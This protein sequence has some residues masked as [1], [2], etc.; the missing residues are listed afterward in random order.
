MRNNFVLLACVLLGFS[1]AFGKSEAQQV[2]SQVPQPAR[3]I[4]LDLPGDPRRPVKLRVP[5]VF[6]PGTGPFPLA[7]WNHGS[8]GEGLIVDEKNVGQNMGVYYLLSRGYAVA[9]PLMRGF[10]QSGG[11][12]SATG[13]QLDDLAHDTAADL[14]AVIDHLAKRSEFAADRILVAGSSFGGWNSLALGALQG[15]RV[16]AI[17]NFYGGLHSS[18]CRN[19]SGALIESS[20]RIGARNPVPS[21]WI[22]GSNDRLFPKPLWQAMHHAYVTRGGQA[23]LVDFGLYKSNSHKLLS[24]PYSIVLF[25][26]KVDRF[27]ASVGLPSKNV[28]P[29]YVPIEPPQPSGYASI[30]DIDAVPF[31]NEQGQALY[32]KF[33]TAVPPRVF[34]I[35]PNA[36]VISETG[37]FDPLARAMTT[38]KQRKVTCWPYAFNDAVVWAYPTP[39]PPPS[40]FAKLE[41][42]DALPYVDVAGKTAYRQFLTAKRPR[43]FVIAPSGAWSMAVGDVDP[44]AAALAKCSGEDHATCRPY[45]VDRMVVWPQTATV[46]H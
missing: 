40:R 44:V 32:K 31:L 8:N 41:D 33:L 20:S 18:T 1:S 43:A 36:V 6:P 3:R 27:L 35:A 23:E 19:D 39:S 7:L 2:G 10:G 21:L 25:A 24:D 34:V 15:A 4:V 28:H 30:N 38:C 29:E 11:R 22:Y 37:G 9:M 46:A 42:V 14:L 5:V 26:D 17:V 45:A 12:L 16:A 13:C